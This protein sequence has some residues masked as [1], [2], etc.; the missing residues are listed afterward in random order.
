MKKTTNNQKPNKRLPLLTGKEM[1][2]LLLNVGD[3]YLAANQKH[4]NFAPIVLNP[5][6]DLP[7][8]RENLNKARKLLKEELS[9]DHICN[10][11]WM[12]SL[13][14]WKL[15][16][17]AK[18]LTDLQLHEDAFATETAQVI[19]VMIRYYQLAMRDFAKRRQEL[20]KEKRHEKRNA[21]R[22]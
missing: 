20:E 22:S 13:E 7:W 12:E 21:T 9:A 14:A 4:P 5:D 16:C 1:L 10:C 8:I 6:A 19:A 15:G 11:E 18:T 17:E 2:K 3:E